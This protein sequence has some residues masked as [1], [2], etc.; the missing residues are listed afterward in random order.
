METHAPWWQ[1][2]AWMGGIWLASVLALAIVAGAIHL[3]L[4]A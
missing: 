2:L 3:W 4:N 1:R